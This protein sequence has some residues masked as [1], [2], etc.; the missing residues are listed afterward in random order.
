MESDSDIAVPARGLFVEGDAAEEDDIAVPAGKGRGKR[1]RGRI[2]LRTA[3]PRA[4]PRTGDFGAYLVSSPYETVVSAAGEAR[5]AEPAALRR[6]EGVVECGWSGA[7]VMSPP[8]R[9]I[10][11]IKIIINGSQHVDGRTKKG[12]KCDQKMTKNDHFVTKR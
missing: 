2:D 12:P 4:V 7:M 8:L 1:G 11:T 9:K 5:L 10:V 3:G 6:V